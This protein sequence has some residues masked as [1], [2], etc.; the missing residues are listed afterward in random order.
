M[1]GDH[2]QTV[3]RGSIIIGFPAT[4]ETNMTFIGPVISHPVDKAADLKEKVASFQT[5]SEDYSAKWP[6]LLSSLLSQKVLQ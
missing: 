6:Q 2:E 1:P 5:K 3:E 4:A